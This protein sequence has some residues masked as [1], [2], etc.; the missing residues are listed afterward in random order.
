[1]PPSVSHGG[2]DQTECQLLLSQLAVK[3]AAD[4]H[5]GTVDLV[6]THNGE[7]WVQRGKDLTQVR[8]IIGAGGPVSFSSD[9]RRVL[10]GAVFSDRAPTVLKPKAPKF[11]LDSRYILF[12]VGLLARSEPQK[13]CGIIKKYLREI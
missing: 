3:I 7:F 4:R 8:T 5:A 12:A 2:A 1:M 11:Y 9:S 13:P 10:S 6:V